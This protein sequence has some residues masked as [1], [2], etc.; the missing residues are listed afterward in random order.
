[1]S[2]LRCTVPQEREQEGRPSSALPMMPRVTQH[3]CAALFFQLTS[4][5]ESVRNNSPRHPWQPRGLRA[6]LAALEKT[7]GRP[8]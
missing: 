4:I 3:T 5:L 1:M 8:E 2:A 7:V 6:I